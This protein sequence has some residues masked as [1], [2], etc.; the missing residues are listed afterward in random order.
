MEQFSKAATQRVA[1]GGG[2]P[3]SPAVRIAASDMSVF[4]HFPMDDTLTLLRCPTCGNSIKI[5]QFA[6]H[7]GAAATSASGYSCF[8]P[9]R[10]LLQQFFLDIVMYWPLALLSMLAH[11]P[12]QSLAATVIFFR[13]ACRCLRNTC[14]GGAGLD[15]AAETK[16]TQD[17][18]GTPGRID[19]A[20]DITAL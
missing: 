10:C 5:D 15:Q 14:P 4:G 11:V 17:L 8:L 13:R 1:N 18:D 16:A 2:P 6:V 20:D 19:N 3:R 7:K 12:T 9:S